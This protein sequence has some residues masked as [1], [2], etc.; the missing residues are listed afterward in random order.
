M[1][2]TTSDYYVPGIL[3]PPEVLNPPYELKCLLPPSMMNNSDNPDIVFDSTA[4]VLH[5]SVHGI[6]QQVFNL[7][8]KVDWYCTCK[9]KSCCGFSS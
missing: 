9:W 6:I 3:N 1:K 7:G 8:Q 4:Q 5:F 2:G